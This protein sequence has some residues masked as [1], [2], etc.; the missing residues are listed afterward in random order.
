[1]INW[2][3]ENIGL[4]N[5]LI[6]AVVILAIVGF[7]KGPSWYRHI[8]EAQY[9]G[10]ANAIVENIS[11]KKVSVQHHSGTNIKTVGYEITYRYLAEIDEYRSKGFIEQ[12]QDIKQLFDQFQKGDTCW[13]EI[14]YLPGNPGESIIK[15][16]Q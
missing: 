5:L 15:G 6:L 11:E 7:L 12:G 4:R 14:G 3:K 10:I 16:I 8:K 2:I 9:E 1:M 13:I